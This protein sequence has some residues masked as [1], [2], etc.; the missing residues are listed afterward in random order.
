MNKEDKIKEKIRKNIKSGRRSN[1]CQDID[2][3]EN[4]LT[5]QEIRCG[6]CQ[7]HGGIFSDKFFEEALK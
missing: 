6:F 7:K 1:I 2:C 5:E 4:L 3:H